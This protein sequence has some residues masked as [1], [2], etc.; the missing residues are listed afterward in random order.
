[1]TRG[2]TISGIVFDAETG[3]PIPDVEI[4]ARGAAGNGASF[5]ARTGSDGRY[6][7][8]GLDPGTY[9][10]GT[11]LDD[12]GYITQFYDDKHRWNDADL[13]AVSEAGAVESIDF[14]LTLGATISGSVIDAQ[15]GLP[16]PNVQVRAGI[17]GEDIAWTDT[18]S[19]GSF[20]LTGLPDGVIEVVAERRRGYLEQRTTFSISGTPPVEG[21]DFGLRLG[22]TISGI[23]VD[24]VTGLPIVDVDINAEPVDDGPGGYA[25]TDFNGRYTMEGLAPGAYSMRVEAHNQGYFDGYYPGQTT[26]ENAV[27]V[28]VAG[29]SWLK[30]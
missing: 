16:I 4:E 17:D 14:G 12:E 18:D 30:Q 13:V 20:T 21:I 10:I 28:T 19:N 24:A 6:T 29:A 22:A 15:T 3:L 1:M 26:R 2:A 25:Q 8:R 5:F 9:R 23:V 7:L 11:N 27:I